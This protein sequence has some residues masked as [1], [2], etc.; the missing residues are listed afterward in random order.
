MDHLRRP[1]AETHFTR[2]AAFCLALLACL[3]AAV[4]CV[5]PQHPPQPL[6]EPVQEVFQ[7]AW[8]E[9]TYPA[10]FTPAPSLASST[11]EGV[12][13]AA[14]IS[15]DGSVSFYVYAPQWGG[16]PTDIALDPLHET[17]VSE[18]RAVQNNREIH[19]LTICAKD[20][21]YCRAYQDTRTQQG[22]VRTVLGIKYRDEQARQRY[23]QDYLR[24]R[25][26]LEQFAD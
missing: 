13:S 16:E 1:G 12:D 3:A 7:G 25:N 2:G 14:F 10:G 6:P 18:N 11:A 21:G 17:L 5:A 23:L 19:W 20:G 15:P 9:I 26:S 24:F 4:G 22:S 8:F